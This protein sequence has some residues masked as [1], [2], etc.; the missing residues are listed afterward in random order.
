MNELLG[1]VHKQPQNY[2]FKIHIERLSASMYAMWKNVNLFIC[3]VHAK[4]HTNVE[5]LRAQIKITKLKAVSLPTLL[6]GKYTKRN[7]FVL[8]KN[9]NIVKCLQCNKIKYKIKSKFHQFSILQ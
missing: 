1:N 3:V 6:M 9:L 5:S 4:Y 2:L 8:K 7:N